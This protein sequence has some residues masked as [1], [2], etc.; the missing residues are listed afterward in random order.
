MYFLFAITSPP[1]LR[2]KDVISYTVEEGKKSVGATK[3]AELDDG[4][5][6]DS[7]HAR[8]MRVTYAQSPQ[9]RK[10]QV[11]IV[12]VYT[13]SDVALPAEGLDRLSDQYIFKIHI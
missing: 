10:Q 13:E 5:V 4:R 6:L 2:D 3:V 1:S 7:L 9:W 11:D 12:S 8:G